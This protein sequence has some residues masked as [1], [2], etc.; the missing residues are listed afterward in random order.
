VAAA[1]GP[2]RSVSSGSALRTGTDGRAPWL[3]PGGRWPSKSRQARSRRRPWYG[4]DAS[5]LSVA[6][7]RGQAPAVCCRLCPRGAR[8][9]AAGWPRHWPRRW[10]RR[11]PPR[12]FR[13]ASGRRPGRGLGRRKRA[14]GRPTATIRL[15]SCVSVRSGRPSRPRTRPTG[16]SGQCTDGKRVRRNFGCDATTGTSTARIPREASLIFHTRHGEQYSAASHRTRR[17]RHRRIVRSSLLP[18]HAAPP[19]AAPAPPASARSTCG[20]PDARRLREPGCA[21]P[22][23]FLAVRHRAARRRGPPPAGRPKEASSLG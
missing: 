13:T 9:A 18:T 7:R 5:G 21:P 19:N 2:T 4:H 6:K 1:A 23:P 15:T 17:D 22:H 16:R 10:P 3:P 8:C 14:P 12:E 20:W 11:W